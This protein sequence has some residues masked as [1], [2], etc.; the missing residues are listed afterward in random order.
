MLVNISYAG[1]RRGTY[2]LYKR[3]F[4]YLYEAREESQ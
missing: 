2:V 1:S 3:T 4:Q